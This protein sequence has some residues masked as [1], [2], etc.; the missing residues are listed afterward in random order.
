M[1]DMQ[2]DIEAFHEEEG[3]NVTNIES[4]LAHED[5]HDYDKNNFLESV[6]NDQNHVVNMIDKKREPSKYKPKEDSSNKPSLA[7]GSKLELKEEAGD[8]RM[9]DGHSRIEALKKNLMSLEVKVKDIQDKRKLKKNENTEQ[10]KKLNVELAAIVEKRKGQPEVT[11]EMI[12]KD[13]EEQVH[14]RPNSLTRENIKLKQE[15]EKLRA[16]LLERNREVDKLSLELKQTRGQRDDALDRIE[17]L[18]RIIES[19]QKQDERALK[20]K[21]KPAAEV[22]EAVREQRVVFG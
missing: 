18:S 11:G 3:R 9:S 20:E 14:H 6:G 13:V 5:L 22:D 21:N 8:S 16:L 1:D 10:Q 7:G 4:R 19:R 17:E 2:D 12:S 15:T